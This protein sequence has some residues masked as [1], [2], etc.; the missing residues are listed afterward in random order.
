MSATNKDPS[1][2]DRGKR[3]A[4][5][6]ADVLRALDVTKIFATGLKRTQE[7]AQIVAEQLDV[8]VETYGAR[9]TK[10]FVD[11]LQAMPDGEVWLVVGHSNT[12]PQMVDAM[13]GELKGLDQ[14]GFLAETEHDR[15]IVQV[16][17]ASDS[18]G[19]MQA[20]RTLD[21]RVSSP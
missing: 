19:P 17:R 16:L 15:V 13:G 2:D 18:D 14:W 4:A 11:R 20:V 21:L 3:R 12:V 6:L 9:K 10:E 7:T 1:L 5:R 8:P